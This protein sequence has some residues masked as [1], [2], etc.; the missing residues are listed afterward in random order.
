MENKPTYNPDFENKLYIARDV[1]GEP[2]RDELEIIRGLEERLSDEESFI[3]I[4]PFGSV[5]GGYNDETSDIDLYVLYNYDEHCD[6]FIIKLSNYQ[7]E[8]LE[9]KHRRLH[10]IPTII[11]PSSVKKDLQSNIE[12]NK[13]GLSSTVLAEMTRVVTGKKIDACRNEIREEIKKLLPEQQQELAESVLDSL[14]RR[15]VLSLRKRTKQITYLSD[16]DHKNILEGRKG[17]WRK[18]IEKIWGI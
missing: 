3:G 6:N 13:S 12:K 4:A 5:I 15:E 10:I 9:K 14:C 8:I 2:N 1:D 18:R 17:M 16:D 11:N 7:S